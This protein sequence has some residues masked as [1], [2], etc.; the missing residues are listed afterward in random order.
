MIVTVQAAIEYFVAIILREKVVLR[1][2]SRILFPLFL[3]QLN[4]KILQSSRLL[5][6]LLYVF[7]LLLQL[8][9]PLPPLLV[10][11]GLGNPLLQLLLVVRDVEAEHEDDGEE[12]D[13]DADDYYHGGR[14]DHFLADVLGEL[15][16]SVGISG[17]VPLGIPGG[18]GRLEVAERNMHRWQIIFLISLVLKKKSVLVLLL[19]ALLILHT[20]LNEFINFY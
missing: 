11:A 17:G 10:I 1:V 9:P 12:A 16:H 18:G 20:I 2:K 5:N 15:I 7:F 6:H 8:L 19:K 14:V 4:I 13:D 3:R